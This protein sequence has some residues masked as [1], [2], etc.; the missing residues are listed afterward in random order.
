MR[1][2]GLV[3]PRLRWPLFR[4]EN[5]ILWLLRD[6]FWTNLAAGS[7]NNT[8]AEP[9]PGVR[10]VVDTGSKLSLSGGNL[11][12]VHPAVSAYGDPGLWYGQV[13]ISAGRILVA[14]LTPTVGTVLCG[15]DD[16]QSGSTPSVGLTFTIDPNI[17]YRT[18]ALS[19]NIG[20]S[21]ASSQKAFVIKRSAGHAL[22]VKS[23]LYPYPTLLW[24]TP[25]AVANAYYPIL[26][27]YSGDMTSSFIRIPLALWLPTPLLSDG[28][29]ES[30]ADWVQA[31]A[32]W[33]G[34]PQAPGPRLGVWWRIRRLR[35]RKLLTTRISPLIP[36]GPNLGE[37]E[38][39]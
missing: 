22:L 35:G 8:N 33:S 29:R 3:V 16:A 23:S 21:A 4:K 28:M 5:A 6:E 9:R 39:Q 10:T 24:I 11:V 37:V 12:L 14:Q 34:T 26:V 1:I 31:A 17:Y 38:R 15:W 13:D 25:T 30:L 7:V 18:N 19:I 32:G 2:R 27:S 20:T 36:G